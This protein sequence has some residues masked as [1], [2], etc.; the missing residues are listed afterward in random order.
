MG[1]ALG[2]IVMGFAADRLDIRRVVLFGATVTALGM[3]VA[4]AARELWQLYAVFF[5]TGAFGGGALFA[6]LFALVGVWFRT[7]AGL[8]IGIVAAGQAIGQGGIPLAN[9]ILIEALGWRGTLL[10]LGLVALATLVPLALLVRIPP[11]VQGAPAEA[12]A[13]VE[14]PIPVRWLV[15]LM[16]AA[17]LCCC[18]LM[19]VPLMHLVPLIQ[20]CGIPAP[21]AGSVVFVMMLAAIAGRVA[22]GRLADMIGAVQAYLAASAWQTALVFVF[23]RIDDLSLFY[24]FAPVYGFGYAGV[25]TGVL[26]TIRSL[27]PAVRRASAS[28]VILAFA[29]AGHGLGG[30]LGGVFFD[31]TGTYDLTFAVAVAAGVANLTVVALV[32]ILVLRRERRDEGLVSATPGVG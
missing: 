2:G 10:A 16:S 25:M 24:I 29:W 18:S 27:T 12:A 28:G 4:S 1:I 5:V 31:M 23:T 30:Y 6:P 21:E 22:F 32:F 19:S 11:S 13:E 14:P 8:A 20:G 26:T 3:I 15:V 17:V 7:G 9:A